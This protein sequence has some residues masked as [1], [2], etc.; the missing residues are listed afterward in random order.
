[1]EKKKT[2]DQ[3]KEEVSKFPKEKPVLPQAPKKKS[4]YADKIIEELIELNKALGAALKDYTKI[5][6]DLIARTH[7]ELTLDDYK[8]YRDEYIQIIMS[9]FRF[10]ATKLRATSGINKDERIDN[11]L[12]GIAGQYLISVFNKL[13]IDESGVI[14]FLITTGNYISNTTLQVMEKVAPALKANGSLVPIMVRVLKNYLD[15]GGMQMPDEE[16]TP[17]T[18]QKRERIAKL[19]KI[20]EG[21]NGK[22]K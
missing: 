3:L 5:S 7:A 1:M 13:K 14:L 22:D 10:E 19:V 12:K 17:F 18:P 4:K 8:K 6:A 21:N 2:I 11:P 20:L 9:C 15:Q 16:M